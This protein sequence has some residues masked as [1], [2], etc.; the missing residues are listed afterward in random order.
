MAAPELGL[1]QVLVEVIKENKGQARVMALGACQS[2]SAANE[3]KAHMAAYELGLLEL[4]VQLIKEDKRQVRVNAL[5]TC[6]NLSYAAEILVP[7]AAP[8]LGLLSVLVEVIKEDKG[9][10]RVK[11]LGVCQN[12]S[13]DPEN[14][15]QMAAPKLGLLEVLVEVMKEDQ[16]QA[17]VSALVVCG[18]LSIVPQNKLSLLEQMLQWIA[19]GDTK[20]II[21]AVHR[22]IFLVQGE[23]LSLRLLDQFIGV[24]ASLLARHTSEDAYFYPLISELW[25]TIEN[26]NERV[27]E[28]IMKTTIPQ[29]LWNHL[30]SAGP[31]KAQWE[32]VEVYTRMLNCAMKR[33][34]TA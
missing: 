19:D 16:G 12:L 33:Q 5:G 1:L 14:Q 28:S 20:T 25:N 18:C 6:W 23:G 31:D 30:Q 27:A 22:G 9:Q 4:M 13:I 8:E 21:S 34:W 29:C 32:P 17:R 2:L 11:A 15:I 26:S 24:L 3:N 10:A 7:M